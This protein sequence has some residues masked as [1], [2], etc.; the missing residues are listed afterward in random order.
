MKP[1]QRP[2]RKM[3]A[4]W[5][6]L[7]AMLAG[8]LLPGLSQ[9]LASARGEAWSAVCTAQGVRWVMAAASD[10]ATDS[11]ANSTTDG[12]ANPAADPGAPLSTVAAEHCPYCT[13]SG[14]APALPSAAPEALPQPARSTQAP[15]LFLHAPRTLF[16]WRGAQPR[17]PP[18]L[19]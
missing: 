9:A 5:L 10:S 8:A 4:A 7:F 11:A 18:P 1:G 12:A 17:A 14:H 13:P 15:A 16:A 2:Q 6:A 19:A 3:A